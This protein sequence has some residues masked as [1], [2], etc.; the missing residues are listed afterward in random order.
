MHRN[1]NLTSSLSEK[2]DMTL[3]NIMRIHTDDVTCITASRTWS[4]IVSGSRDGSAVIWELN[5]GGYVRSIWHPRRTDGDTT[6][7]LVAINESTVRSRSCS[8]MPSAEPFFCVRAS[9]RHV[10]ASLFAYIPLTAAQ[11]RPSISPPTHHFIPH[12][13]PQ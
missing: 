1:T 11:L 2:L 10:Q 4:I 8:T 9:L 6:V 7:N 12:M 3:S 13:S 5:R